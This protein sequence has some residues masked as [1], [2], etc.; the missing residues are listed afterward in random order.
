M[1]RYVHVTSNIK[2]S[3]VVEAV[4]LTLHTDGPGL[5]PWF[6]DHISW[7]RLLLYFSSVSRQM[8]GQYLRLY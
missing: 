2:A 3:V 5:K 4:E 1:L 6:W 8:A 7:L